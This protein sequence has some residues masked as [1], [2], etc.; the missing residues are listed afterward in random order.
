MQP[1]EGRVHH[2]GNAS[3]TAAA[4]MQLRVQRKIVRGRMHFCSPPFFSLPSPYN[5]DSYAI[6]HRD[7][8]TTLPTRQ[9]A[10]SPRVSYRRVP[11]KDK[12][13]IYIYILLRFWYN[14]FDF[15]IRIKSIR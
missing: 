2:G 4:A 3:E 15:Y 9:W 6:V 1:F 11:E 13:Y 14:F 7:G 5:L 10:I 8:Q 12:R